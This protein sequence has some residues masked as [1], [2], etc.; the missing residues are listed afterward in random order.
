MN[1]GIVGLGRMGM[2][3][4]ARLARA[5]HMVAGYDLDPSKRAEAGRQG[6]VFL[7]SLAM[8]PNVLPAPKVVIIMVPAGP[9]VDQAIDGV[10]PGLISGDI[11]IGGDKDAFNAKVIAALLAGIT[12]LLSRLRLLY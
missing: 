1:V 11:V 6:I 12:C 10:A 2:G 3:M 4:G 8:L 9:A 5:G 7:D